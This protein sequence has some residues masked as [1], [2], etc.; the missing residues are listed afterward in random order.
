MKFDALNLNAAVLKVLNDLGNTNPTTLQETIIPAFLDGKNAFVKA[1]D[2]QG[3]VEVI[4]I[5]TVDT[6]SKNEDEEG[7]L[8][9]ILTPNPK[10]AHHIVGQISELAKH[11][12]VTSASIDMD[13][14][15]EAQ[16]QAVVNGTSVLVANPGRLLDILEDNLFVFRN[17]KFLVIDGLD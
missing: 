5:T 16:E 1:G 10:G 3:K 14:E 8:V 9:L 13:G 7:T 17:L 2:I 11:E 6:I 15:R 4:S 12:E